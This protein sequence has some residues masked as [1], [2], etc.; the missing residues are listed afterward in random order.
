M[1]DGVMEGTAA[2][3]CTLEATNVF[4]GAQSQQITY[5][6]GTGEWGIANRSLNRWGMNFVAG[7]EYDGCL[8]VRADQPVAVTVSLESQD[9]A[10]VYASQDL[11]VT[12]NTWEHVKFSLTPTNGDGNGR[13]VIGLK[14]PGSVQVGYAFLEPGTWGLYQGSAGAAGCGG[15]IDQSGDHRSAVWGINGECGRVSVEEHGWAAGPAS[16]LRGDMVS[17]FN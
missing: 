10:S 14:Q 1:W 17:V 7:N 9:G 12:S 5:T 8:D 3:A 2:G 15:G 4:V 13:F 11:K 16:A 6:G